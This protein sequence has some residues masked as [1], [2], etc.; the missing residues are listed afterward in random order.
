MKKNTLGRVLAIIISA[1]VLAGCG[2]TG[3]AGGQSSGGQA[4]SEQAPGGLTSTEQSLAGT[5]A[6]N[7]AAQDTQ[8]SL[9][10][11]AGGSTNGSG[12]DAGGSGPNAGGGTNLNPPGTSSTARDSGTEKDNAQK[13][14]AQKDEGTGV[15]TGST[16]TAEGEIPIG[17][18]LDGAE[19]VLIYD[20]LIYDEID[21]EQLLRETSLDTG[22]LASQIVTGS[23]RADD[24]MDMLDMPVL[25]SQGQ[26]NKDVNRDAIQWNGEKGMGMD[27]VYSKGDRHEF[28][29]FAGDLSLKSRELAT[30]DC[31]YEGETCYIW[32]YNQSISE[33]EAAE[34]GEEFDG[35]IYQKD[36]DAFGQGRFTE[37]GGKVN[38]LMYPMQEQLGGFFAMADIFSQGELSP[39]YENL[40]RPNY[41]HAIINI[42]SEMLSENMPYVKSTLAHEFQ[43]LICASEIF[44]TEGT[45]IMRTWL[46]EAMSAYAEE[47]VYPGIKEEGMYNQMMYLSDF[48]RTGQSLYNFGTEGDEYIGAYG[49]VYLFSQYLSQRTGDD[50]FY[51]VHEFWRTEGN[52]AMDEAAALAGAVTKDFYQEIDKSY[53]YPDQ[54]SR[55][56]TSP[57]EEWMSKLTLCFYMESLSGKLAKL[58]EYED[59]LRSCCLYSELDP[60]QIEGGGRMLV[61]S[62]DGDFE[63]PEN[64]D[65]GLLY[66]GLDA[67][68][69][70]IEGKMII[71]E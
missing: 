7:Q 17:T 27:P 23:V 37:D 58:E 55:A 9:L 21:P 59:A 18:R 54:V 50:I 41:D 62:N 14:D 4:S 36:V 24:M 13:D 67:D 40:L 19:Y 2:G 10:Q 26:I 3:S 5:T 33:E 56:F 51:K 70:P 52:P 11:D 6:V 12:P 30:F 43:H 66:I 63:V 25:L 39:Q 35:N 34:L 8:E 46:N 69:H 49:A 42:N 31:I 32:S 64:A 71:G 65:S 53:D 38:I 45:P 28:Y 60:Q 57:A 48:Y 61:Q 44:Y 29:C 68:F 22:D 16:Q 15:D 1:A 20:P 47:M